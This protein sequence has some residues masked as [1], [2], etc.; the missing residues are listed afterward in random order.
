MLDVR[1]HVAIQYK[2]FH[3]N[4]TVKKVIHSLWDMHPVLNTHWPLPISLCSSASTSLS[5]ISI[6]RRSDV[7]CSGI[8]GMFI[9]EDIVH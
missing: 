1:Y 5:K 9:I 8:T 4:I 3:D 2:Y 6:N 7:C